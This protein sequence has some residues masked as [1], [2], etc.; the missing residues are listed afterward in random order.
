MSLIRVLINGSKGRMGQESVKAVNADPELDLVA[1]TDIS[2][3]LPEII[4]KTKAQVV[5]DFTT[6]EVAMEVSKSIIKSG[7]RP[8]IGTSGLL[9]EQVAELKKLCKIQ[10]IGGVIAPNFAIGAVLMMKYAEDA[11]KYFPD[12]EII[13]LHHN[14]K[15]D[16]PS[17][18]AIKTANLIAEARTS[19]PD[20]IAEKEILQ[21]ARGANADEIRIHSVRLPGL[22]AHQEVLFGGQSQTLT[23]R[24][25]SIHRDSFMP[26]VCLACKKV[27]DLNELVYGLEHLL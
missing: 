1:E 4:A 15:V 25:N 11:A 20:K 10:N 3:N 23:I 9:P 13:E 8:V 22:V 27:I 24:H 26:G 18:T 19:I 17:G 12:V 7:A 5:L 14:G 6:A 21:G 2:D 16:S